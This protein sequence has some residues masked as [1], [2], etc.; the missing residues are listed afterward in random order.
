[1]TEQGETF[2]ERLRTGYDPLYVET[3]HAKKFEEHSKYTFHPLIKTHM[4]WITMLAEQ[5]IVPR[6]SAKKVC[7]A[8]KEL[9]EK[10]PE[11]LLPYIPEHQDVYFHMEKYLVRQIGQEHV[12][13]LA[14]GR[15]RP[16]PLTR[17]A[18]RENLLRALEASLTLRQK[19]LDTAERNVQTV[20]T[21][22]THSQPA[23]ATTFGHYLM[24]VHDP[25]A[26]DTRHLE[27]AYWNINRCTM[28]C[29][30][31]VGTSFSIDRQRVADLLGFD[32]LIENTHACVAS[33]DYLVIC[34]TA[35][36]DTMVTISRC[37]Q[38]INEWCSYEVGMTLSAPQFSD[39]S[40]MMP[41]K[42]N[43]AVFERLR[44][45]PSLTIAHA[46]ALPIG[47]IKSHYADAVDISHSMDPALTVLE[48]ATKWMLLFGEVV[49]TA[50][51][52]KER[53]LQMAQ[54]N[55][56]TI[57]MLTDEIYRRTALPYRTVHGI[58]SN[59]VNQALA[60]GVDALGITAEMVDKAAQ[61]Y[62]GKPIEMSQ[63]DVARCLDPVAFMESHAVVGGPA[64]KEVRR[65]IA[66]RREELAA[67]RERLAARRA[68]LEKG[69]RLLEEAVAA[70]GR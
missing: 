54:R 8:L 55:F 41:Q 56:C 51:L 9:G 19:L 27:D 66:A 38:D 58:V 40:S 59:V 36:T 21:G 16:E 17:M 1:M 49:S 20:M 37:A 25:I 34:G 14:L 57:S 45:F 53:M 44:F 12:G 42:Y 70:I 28:G 4:A 5:G 47:L 24:A 18:L 13:Y 52:N 30:A 31:M 6:A 3:V 69:N 33:N 62:V 68:R 64:P 48:E 46:Q 22:Y 23:Q 50:T 43:P 32:G 39:F 67:A 29:G 26:E 15:T 10:G 63:S 7:Q 60:A 61:K 11:A 65:M 2:S 35:V